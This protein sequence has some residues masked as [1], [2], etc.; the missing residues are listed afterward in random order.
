SRAGCDA[1]LVYTGMGGVKSGAA[2]GVAAGREKSRVGTHILIWI[3]VRHLVAFFIGVRNPVP[4]QAEVESQAVVDAPVILDV[5]GPGSVFPV[6]GALQRVFGIL[7]RVAE[8]EVREVVA[9]ERSVEVVVTLGVLEP[10][11]NLFVNGPTAAH[12][13]LVAALGPGN[14]VADL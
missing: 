1:P 9:G 12:L 10:V 4:T 13:E 7:L 2:D 3:E 8:Q 14:V 6:S 5:K 11:L